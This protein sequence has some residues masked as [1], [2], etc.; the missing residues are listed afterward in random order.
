MI[1]HWMQK[2]YNS[3]IW[4]IGREHCL[5]TNCK[6]TYILILETER[7]GTMLI[8][9]ILVYFQKLGIKASTLLTNQALNHYSV[10]RPR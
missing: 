10:A 7:P 2:K 1:L 5:Q 9:N 6:A 3:V 4:A 8:D